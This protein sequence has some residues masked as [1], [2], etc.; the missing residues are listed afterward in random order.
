MH[1]VFGELRVIEVD[2]MT[3]FV[4]SD[5]SKSLGYKR[6]SDA[7]KHLRDSQ[8]STA[9]RR[10]GRDLGFPDG[11]M[12]VLVTEGGVHRLALRSS[13][14]KAE[15][16]QEWVEDEILPEIRRDATFI[17]ADL[18]NWGKA[19][20]YGKLE[21]RAFTDVLRDLYEVHGSSQP[22]HRWAATY[23]K[24]MTKTALGISDKEF[25]E[26][27]L[28]AGGNFRSGATEEELVRLSAAEA[29]VA[30]LIVLGRLDDIKALYHEAK[31]DL[32]V[33]A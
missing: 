28:A 18:S 19:R 10:T 23:T 31:E 15:E 17:P 24:M 14:P 29:R 22:F 30:S 33:F 2:G 26:R 9:N 3:Q 21:R 27:K 32:G 25:T 16:Y 6:T 12:P 20:A 7:K 8:Y 11:S 1:E 5:V 13:L 4:L